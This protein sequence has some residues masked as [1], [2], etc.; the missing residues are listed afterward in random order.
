MFAKTK[1]DQANKQRTFQTNKDAND[2]NLETIAEKTRKQQKCFEK[3]RG[4]VDKQR[5]CLLAFHIEGACSPKNRL[6]DRA[7]T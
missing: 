1:R 3:H 6:H 7:R 2:G 4:L 5:Q